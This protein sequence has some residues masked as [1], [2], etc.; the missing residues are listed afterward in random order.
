[1]FKQK[2]NNE[3][4]MGKATFAIRNYIF[5]VKKYITETQ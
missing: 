5:Y 4:H 1:M 3:T 2:M